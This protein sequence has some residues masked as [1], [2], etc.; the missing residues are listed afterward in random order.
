VRAEEKEQEVKDNQT[1]IEWMENIKNLG[2]EHF[3]VDG[4]KLYMKGINITVPEFLAKE[5]AV[6]REDEEEKIGRG[7][8]KSFRVIEYQMEQL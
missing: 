2:D 5:F 6:R 7:K 8:L 3:E 4:F 1:L